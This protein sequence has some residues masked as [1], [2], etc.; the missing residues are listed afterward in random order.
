MDKIELYSTDVIDIDEE[1]FNK[2][3]HS[4]I[5]NTTTPQS[6]ISVEDLNRLFKNNNILSDY[7]NKKL[8]NAWVFVLKP[9]NSLGDHIDGSYSNYNRLLFVI[10]ANE[11]C[12]NKFFYKNENVIE[13]VFSNK[14]IYWF[15]SLKI[16]HNV[17][18][19]GNTNRISLILDVYNDTEFLLF[20]NSNFNKELL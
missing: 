19:N 6:P 3:K 13:K 14:K 17:L 2:I 20:I 11:N 4:Y 10:E 15:D 5:N 8:I 1:F 12:I 16:K 9:G 7:F 18:N